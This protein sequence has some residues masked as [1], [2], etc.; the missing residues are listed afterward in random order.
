[1][2]EVDGD[3]GIALE[4]ASRLLSILDRPFEVYDLSSLWRV[5]PTAPP[6]IAPTTS[7]ATNKHTQTHRP[8]PNRP[9]ATV[10]CSTSLA[11]AFSSF[12]DCGKTSGRRLGSTS[13]VE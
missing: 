11:E 4:E 5:P 8:F 2:L 1:V 12:L 3:A 7:R 13:R 9:F 6:M 10:G